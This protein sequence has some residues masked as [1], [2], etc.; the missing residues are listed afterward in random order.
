[1]TQWNILFWIASGIF[2]FGALVFSIFIS[3]KPEAWGRARVGTH[4]QTIDENMM[5]PDNY[6]GGS[7]C[8]RGTIREN[9]NNDIEEN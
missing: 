7:V 8:I 3:A 5:S 2:I 1:M 4:R 6:F 9:T